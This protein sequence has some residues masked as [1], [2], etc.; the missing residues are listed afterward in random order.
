MYIGFNASFYT[1]FWG[2]TNKLGNFDYN[3]PSVGR[4]YENGSPTSLQI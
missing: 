1:L 2:I 4:F 3:I